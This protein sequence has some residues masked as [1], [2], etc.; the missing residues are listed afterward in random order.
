VDGARY[1]PQTRAWTTMAAYPR[2]TGVGGGQ[3]SAFTLGDGTIFTWAGT[4]SYYAAAD[5]IV[6]NSGF[7]PDAP[8]V[9]GGARYK[10]GGS[11]EPLPWPPAA[12][13]SSK[14]FPVAR[15]AAWYGNGRFWIW[16]GRDYS[17]ASVDAGAYY[18]VKEDRWGAMPSTNAPVARNDATV[19]WT[20]A[21][22]V[23]WAGVSGTT[24]LRDGGIFRP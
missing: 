10:I 7:T 13:F 8:S 17:S 2:Q 22:A 1:D 15:S 16:S 14:N 23:V 6:T 20:G 3:R 24:T 4:N 11:W 21:E 5:S 9:T 19:V 18:D 12:A